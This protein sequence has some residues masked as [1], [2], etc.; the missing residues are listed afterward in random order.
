MRKYLMT[1]M[2]VIGV[3]TATNAIEAA[4]QQGPYVSALG[5]V[6]FLDVDT[7]NGV[8]TNSSTGYVLGGAL[9]YKF[10]S[11]WRAEAEL[12]YRHNNI[13]KFKYNGQKYNVDFDINS[14]TCMAN[15]YYDIDTGSAITPYFG[16][17]IG[18]VHTHG[19]VKIMDEKK[20]VSSNGFGAQLMVGANYAIDCKT[21]IGLEYRYLYAHENASDN[22][23]LLNLR[24]YF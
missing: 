7:I 22:A 4:P 8:H 21:E 16:S 3:F 11:P 2:T 5:G 13:D 15:L 10:C 1:L 19:K 20:E 23:I 12:T 17:G 18:Y 9:G 14:Y 24:R 6:N